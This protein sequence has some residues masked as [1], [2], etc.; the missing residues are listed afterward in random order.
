VRALAAALCAVPV[1][2]LAD[3]P[4]AVEEWT[5]APS[6]DAPLEPQL[7]PEAP[8]RPPRVWA[9]VGG[10]VAVDTRFEPGP[11][12]GWAE[13]V[14]D[15]RAR[16]VVG[17]EI[18]LGDWSSLSLEARTTWRAAAQAGWA[19]PKADAEARLGEAYLDLYGAW[20]DL[21]IG[22]QR[23]PLGANAALA[24]ADALNAR[25]LREGALFGDPEATLLPA[26]GIR[27]QGEL[28][29]VRWLAA[30]VPFFQ[31]HRYALIGQDG[32]L[33]QPAAEAYV[34][35][36]LDPSVEDLA[37]ERLLETARPSGF[38]AS[39]DL[40]VRVSADLWG[41]RLGAGWLWANEKL[42]AVSVDPEL[43]YLMKA[44]ALERAPDP[45]VLLSVQSRLSAGEALFRGTYPRRHLIWAEASRIIG[46]VQVDV[47]LAWSPAQ[48]FFTDGLASLRRPAAT[49]VVGASP[50]EAGELTYAVTYLG[51]AVPG[52]P[53]EELLFLV[54]PFTARGAG[55][56][57][58]LHLLAGG[59]SRTFLEGAL[60]VA[61]AAAVEPI[62]R[63]FAVAPRVTY[64]VVDR[65]RVGLSAA[66]YE[67]PPASPF[68]YVDR[69]D[70]VAVGVE[71]EPR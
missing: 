44:V 53:A 25:D 21:R 9:R 23:L 24:P 59:V 66:F 28:G 11:E 45:A 65:V 12:V 54:E 10:Q 67:G 20:A 68:G 58:W 49:W 35:L 3:G 47:D 13:N 40:A 48:T 16:A 63:S 69:N 26:L 61:V 42:P 71:W 37:A 50:S 22:W 6:D 36:V 19:R 57:A 27:A 4:D 46:P 29:P 39:G 31:P 51:M 2:A 34:P 14:L 38:G 60:E 33:V 7:Q 5:A 15:A 41:T 70:Q 17:A 30:Y 32:A 43:A 62:Q 52:V 64:E 55:R 1:V 18:P 56:T 8:P